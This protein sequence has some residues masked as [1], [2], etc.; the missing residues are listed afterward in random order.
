MRP[1]VVVLVL[2]GL[3][4]AGARTALPLPQP[5]DPFTLTASCVASFMTSLLPRDGSCL[6]AYGPRNVIG[7]VVRHYGPHSQV[8]QLAPRRQ[9]D[10]LHLEV[11]NTT[12][13]TLL[14]ADSDSR[15]GPRGHFSLANMSHEVMN[16]GAVVVWT[17]VSTL[18]LER[19]GSGSGRPLPLCG[20][21]FYLIVTLADGTSLLYTPSCTKRNV[22]LSWSSAEFSVL[23]RCAPGRG[24]QTRLQPVCSWWRP[25]LK[26]PYSVFSFRHEYDPRFVLG[27]IQKRYVESLAAAMSSR[28]T[29]I[30]DNV[31]SL[32][33]HMDNCSLGAI[34]MPLSSSLSTERN[35]YGHGGY[36]MTALAAVVPAGLGSPRPRLLQAVTAEFSV[37]LWIATA[38]AQV[39]MTAATAVAWVCAGR[40][41]LAALAA[42]GLQTLAPLL[43]QPPPGAPAHRQLAAVWLLMSVVIAAAYQ[44]LLLRELSSAA[45]SD[46][47]SL[48]QL[49]RTGMDV[50]VP[51]TYFGG[52]YDLV[53]S[54]CPG[55]QKRLKAFK[56]NTF[57][58]ILEQVTAERNTAALFHLGG[59]EH[60]MMEQ[61]SRGSPKLLHL[62]PV[63]NFTVVLAEARFTKGS[64]VGAEAELILNRAQEG[65]LTS[66]YYDVMKL[67]IFRY[68]R[69]SRNESS[70][71][72]AR[73]LTLEQMQPAFLVLAVGYGLSGLVLVG[74]LLWHKWTERQA[75]AVIIFL[76]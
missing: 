4:G 16:N 7:P 69:Q 8:L 57:A 51:D 32:V 19:H 63:P 49:N 70:T 64:P 44:G 20:L 75:P 73:P 68:L 14:A 30:H 42:T 48:E 24:W 9:V 67:H 41:P 55:L 34:L 40:P 58:D 36:R 33:L 21:R 65:G 61:L 43:G 22:F 17:S 60:F 62:F 18:S 45:T 27:D 66:H 12:S 76:H 13:V 15:E 56:R 23:D 74:E 31:S 54:I 37:T 38:L 6:V 71:G 59:P 26:P 29:W 5:A 52:V 2:L 50:Y 72:L 28:L 39:S 3:L 11:S 25:G 1:P 10:R 53:W 47:D 35:H 46:I